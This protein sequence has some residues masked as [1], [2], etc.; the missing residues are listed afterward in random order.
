MRVFNASA[1]GSSGEGTSVAPQNAAA[2]A[3]SKQG[4]G[5]DGCGGGGQ[6]AAGGHLTCPQLRALAALAEALR[7]AGGR[8]PAAEGAGHSR[9]R[10]DEGRPGRPARRVP[11]QLEVEWDKCHVVTFVNSGLHAQQQNLHRRPSLRG[12]QALGVLVASDA[13]Y[14]HAPPLDNATAQR[15]NSAAK[16]LTS[17]VYPRSR[18]YSRTDSRSVTY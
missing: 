14:A 11:A 7:A 5:G 12:A 2:A 9:G 10:C 8:V 16:Q 15:H 17:S 3:P 13:E 1:H 4:C 18:R 6:G